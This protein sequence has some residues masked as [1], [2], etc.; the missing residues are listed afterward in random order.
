MITGIVNGSEALCEMIGLGTKNATFIL[1]NS[2]TITP[3]MHDFV[4]ADDPKYIRLA[5]DEDDPSI[6]RRLRVIGQ[7]GIILYTLI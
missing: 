3:G 1:T 7:N 4:V 5:T 6:V 2:E